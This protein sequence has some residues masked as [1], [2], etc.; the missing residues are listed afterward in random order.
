MIVWGRQE[1]KQPSPAG[2]QAIGMA[3]LLVLGVVGGLVLMAYLL[4]TDD[5]RQKRAG[6]AAFAALTLHPESTYFGQGGSEQ[7]AQS[8]F[9]PYKCT[10]HYSH[11]RGFLA[12]GGM[13]GVY[14]YYRHQADTLGWG[15]SYLPGG[16]MSFDWEARHV[17]LLVKPVSEEQIANVYGPL[18][19][20]DREANGIY[21]FALCAY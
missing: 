15:T 14:G 18:N 1:V 6:E 4:N 21:A 8:F 17:S 16:G 11:L 13:E 9:T 7:A 5:I 20:F 12:P 19:W 10:G 3:A 2:R